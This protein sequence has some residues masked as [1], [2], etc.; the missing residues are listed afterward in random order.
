MINLFKKIC[1]ATIIIISATYA[2]YTFAAYAFS[3]YDAPKYPANFTHFDHVNPNAPKGGDLY[4]PNTDRRTSFDKFNPFSMK[5]VV[6]A[7]ISDLMFETLTTS[8]GD[9]TASMY[10]LLASDMQVENDRMSITFTI[11]PKARF[12]N[13]DP[14]LAI[15]VK[16]SF[17]KLVTKGNPQFKSIFA[18]IKNCVITGERTIRFDFKT[19]NRELPLIAGG[20]PVFSHKWGA[21]TSFD[22]I[23]LEMPIS[24]GP[25]VIDRYQLG[26]S[27]HYKRNPHYWAQ[28]LPSRAGMFNF[29]RIHYQLYK[30]DLAKLEAFKAGEFDFIAEYS[31]KNW[32][33]AYNGD[34][35]KNGDLIKRTLTHFNGAGM[36]GFVM[37]LR[38]PQFQDVR[39]RQALELALD[40][41]WMN[42][43]L[44]YKQYK[45]SY[46]FF[47]NSDM[48]AT[49]LP[50]TDELTL[51]AHLKNK[52]DPEVFGQAPVPANTNP[53]GSLRKN[54]LQ[55]KILLKQ[56]G[57]EYRDGALRNAQGTPFSFEI[58]DDQSAMSRVISVYV[59][60]LAK[61]GITVKQ[62]VTDFALLQQR[63]DDF[64]FDMTTTRL[65]D[66]LSPG[67]EMFDLF[68]SKS[69]DQKGSS[70][71]A[72]LK[73]PAVDYLI[74]QLVAA[75]T[76]KEL[77][78]RARAL[79]RVLLHKH[80]IV[81][82][83][84]STTHRIAY[85][86]RF[87]MP[88]NTPRYYQAD[89]WMIS[90]WWAKQP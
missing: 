70:N 16:H 74:S 65:P 71:L 72:G 62:R 22:K 45:R 49:G 51:F 1:I 81:P 83:W 86:N 68:S 31:A 19:N 28:N 5:G 12:N 17:D 24:S 8:S 61:L 60:N 85:K 40:Y 11:N 38:R 78:T 89:G 69:A 39:V 18:D 2:N 56:A 25:Y 79:D 50:S 35:F 32:A 7:G 37:N 34:K 9:E 26:R 27:I 30:D 64:D 20:L 66:I 67:N 36:Q 14:V 76:R 52:I 84:F 57:W 73:D 6:A 77:N 59:R 41:E 43:Q 87:G 15:D 44:F 10:G 33:R 54:L 23:Q 88:D 47:N 82:H 53:P 55:A 29:D 90:H 42:R 21:N 80:M 48:A 75:Q 4:L 58:L 63:I 3:L 13:S 46:S